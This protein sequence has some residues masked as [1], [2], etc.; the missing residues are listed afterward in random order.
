VCDELKVKSPVMVVVP[1]QHR[2]KFCKS[3]PKKNV[4]QLVLLEFIGAE[5]IFT[6]QWD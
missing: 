5:L 1:P 4:P 3:S 6:P 2:E